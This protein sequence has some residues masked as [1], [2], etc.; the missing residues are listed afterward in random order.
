MTAIPYTNIKTF[1]ENLIVLAQTNSVGYLIA[2][3]I[4]DW[5]DENEDF[6]D[7]ELSQ[8]DKNALLKALT[9]SVVA[10]GTDMNC[11]PVG[12]DDTLCFDLSGNPI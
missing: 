10:T 6:W 12:Y 1:A 4:Q 9:G 5:I 8:D 11:Y 2:E 7:L 3:V